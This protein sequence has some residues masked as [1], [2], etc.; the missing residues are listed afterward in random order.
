MRSLAAAIALASLCA[1]AGYTNGSTTAGG[2]DGNIGLDQDSGPDGGPDGG[3]GGPDGGPDA[4][5]V[6]R[7]LNGSAIDYCQGGA[8]TTINGFV[9][10]PAQGCTV[11]ISLATASTPCRGVASSGTLDAFDGG[12]L[13]TGFACTSPSLPGV[14][15]CTTGTGSCTILICDGGTCP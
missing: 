14:L 6:A 5:C 11:E 13:G 7:S 9:N 10:G 8:F 15:T 4:G 3:D 1:C 12:C 2:P